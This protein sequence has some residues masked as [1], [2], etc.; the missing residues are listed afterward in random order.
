VIVEWSQNEA[1]KTTVT[2]YSVRARERATVSAP[3]SGEE[4]S[5]CRESGDPELLSF[6]T[7]QVLGRV[8]EHGDL[9]GPLTSLKQEL[10]R[11]E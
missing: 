7:E 9:F 8:A 2:V 6:D 1:H 4:V 10:P 11:L 5:R 3:V